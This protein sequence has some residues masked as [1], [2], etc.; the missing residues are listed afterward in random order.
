MTQPQKTIAVVNATGR[1]AASLIRVAS[2]VGYSVRAQIHSLKGVI[3]PELQQLPNVTLLQ[4]P[5]LGNIALMDELFKGAQLAFINTTSQSGDE[6]AIGRDLAD[7]AKRSGSIQHYIYSSMPDHSVHGPWP[8]V[9]QWAPKFTVE[10][11]VRQLGMPATFV[12]AGIYNNNFTSLPY[13]LFQMELLEDG[14]FEWRAPFDPEIPLPWLDAEHDVGPT[15]LQIFKDGTKKWNGHR[16][17]QRKPSFRSRTTDPRRESV[18]WRIP[19]ETKTK[20]SANTDFSLSIALTFETLSPL[21]VCA[22]FSRALDRPCRYVRSLKIEIKVNIPPGYR[23]QLEA[24]EELFGRC[25]APYFPQPEFSQPAAGSPKGL[26]PAGGKGAGAGMMQGPGG[27]VSL[28]VTDESRHLWQGWRDMEE[29]AREVFPVE[30][31]AN[32]LD[33]MV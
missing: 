30:E 16:L 6:V 29:Y 18:A 3:A 21:Q 24:L 28:R 5:L 19:R 2:A 8:A 10:N 26:G 31:E 15:L 1:Q 27:V 14:S 33:W 12:Y 32:G 17:V 4:G 20:K 25:G 23:E 11:Y 22:A 13:P 7:A 9:P